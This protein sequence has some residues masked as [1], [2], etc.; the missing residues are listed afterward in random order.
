MSAPDKESGDMRS[1]ESSAS[2]WFAWRERRGLV[3]ATRD[4]YI[5]RREGW[6]RRR[7]DGPAVCG[8]SWGGTD[9]PSTGLLLEQES[10]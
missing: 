4:G 7:Q 1:F 5:L 9:F 3:V 8:T 6:F 10:R 2:A